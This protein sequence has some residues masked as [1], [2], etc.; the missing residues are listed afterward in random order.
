MTSLSDTIIEIDMCLV[1]H[2]AVQLS[3]GLCV[4]TGNIDKSS[5]VAEH[6]ICHEIFIMTTDIFLD[7]RCICRVLCNCSEKFVDAKEVIRSS[8]SKRTGQK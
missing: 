8:K 5:N 1:M 3:P 6:F 7:D 4:W 2:F